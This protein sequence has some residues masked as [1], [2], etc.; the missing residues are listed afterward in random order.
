MTTARDLQSTTQTQIRDWLTQIK[1]LKAKLHSAA[2]LDKM[3]YYEDIK[4]LQAKLT[5]ARK[6][7]SA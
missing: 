2:P 6:K 5:S 7:G 1:E 4:T 3:R